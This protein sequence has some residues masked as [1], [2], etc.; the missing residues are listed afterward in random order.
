MKDELALK[1]KKAMEGYII[2]AAAFL[3]IAILIASSLITAVSGQN[4]AAEVKKEEVN[5]IKEVEKEEVNETK[6]VEK[7]GYNTNSQ[8]KRYKNVGVDE[9]VDPFRFLR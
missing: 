6:E 7:I 5:E 9:S 8:Q 4:I 3:I 1:K 2:K